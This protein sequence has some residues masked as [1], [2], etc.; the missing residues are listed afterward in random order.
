MLK[1]ISLSIREKCEPSY[2][3]ISEN[4]Y[5][6]LYNGIYKKYE[7][8]KLSPLIK[9]ESTISSCFKF[10]LR[11]NKGSITIRGKHKK[12]GG[13]T[14]ISIEKNTIKG[15]FCDFCLKGVW[16]EFKGNIEVDIDK[17]VSNPERF[18]PEKYSSKVTI[19]DNR[20]RKNS[21]MFSPNNKKHCK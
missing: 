16:I 13:P 7:G 18:I 14:D 11:T 4:E 10:I 2:V 20:K 21:V 15:H 1:N 6:I 19:R 17:F 12:E 9:K 8:N 3:K 5:E